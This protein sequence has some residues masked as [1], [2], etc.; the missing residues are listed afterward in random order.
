VT[1]YE[2]VCASQVLQTDCTHDVMLAKVL[3]GQY[4]PH[5]MQATT[6]AHDATVS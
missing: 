1:T 2:A 5:G 4:C 3:N 6:N